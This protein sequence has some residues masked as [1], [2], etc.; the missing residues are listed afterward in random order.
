[1]SSPI[2]LRVLI[3]GGTGEASAL[4]RALAGDARFD[5]TIS[6]AGRTR[7]PAPQPLPA[8]TGGFGGAAGLAAWLRAESVQALVDATHPF[9]AQISA[10]A[11]AAAQETGVPLLVLRRPAWRPGPGD[12]WTLVPSMH[13][14]AEALG[15]APKRA[16]LTVGRK[17]LLPFVA[18]P[19]HFYLIRSVDPPGGAVP[20]SAEII[21]ARGPFAEKDERRLLQEHRIDVVVTKN[22]G[23]AATQAK[24][25]AARALGIAVIMVERP[26]APAAESVEDVAAALA[27][28][29][30]ALPRGV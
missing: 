11:V 15:A 30:A 13:A 7:N 20:P 18:A 24:L 2:P 25:A 6:L 21:A 19:Q 10:N 27:W 23:G 5:A 16:F 17:D 22:S 8:R 4:G 14:A 28:L 3:L 1:M 9:A 29:H 26:P 12:A